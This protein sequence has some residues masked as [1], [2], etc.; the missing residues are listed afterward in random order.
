MLPISGPC[1]LNRGHSLSRKLVSAHVLNGGVGGVFDA[2]NHQQA[3]GTNLTASTGEA[4]RRLT[5]NGTSSDL[6]APAASPLIS[7]SYPFSIAVLAAWT[8]ATHMF[9]VSEASTSNGQP[10]VGLR[11]ND[12]ANRISYF[13]RNLAITADAGA[14]ASGKNDGR[15]HL[16]V[17]VSHA[18]DDHRLYL[19]GRRI[20]TAG[21]SVTAPPCDNFTVG[22][23]RRLGTALWFNGSI[24]GAWRWGRGLTAREVADLWVDPFRMFRPSVATLGKVPTAI[25]SSGRLALLGVG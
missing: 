23:F 20:A 4:G 19:D 6:Q 25:V 11:V 16:L 5:F 2:V 8:S 9:L 1:V 24:Y 12:A 18:A 21:A 14:I 3:V 22:Q 13:V 17:G 7:V 10:C 15:P